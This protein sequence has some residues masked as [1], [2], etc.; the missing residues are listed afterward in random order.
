[1]FDLTSSQ[2]A[3]IFSFIFIICYGHYITNININTFLIKNRFYT[4]YLIVFA[5]SFKDQR[6]KMKAI[7]TNINSTPDRRKA[8]KQVWRLL[9]DN[10]YLSFQ[11]RV[12]KFL[13]IAIPAFLILYKNYFAR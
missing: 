11:I 12:L 7:A 4:F 8:K 13:V 3:F 5:P 2:V 6:L 9:R 10:A 1:M